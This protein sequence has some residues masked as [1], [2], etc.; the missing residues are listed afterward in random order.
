MR[1]SEG[2]FLMATRMRTKYADG[3]FKPATVA[4]A[5]DEAAMQGHRRHRVVQDHPFDLSGTDAANALEDWLDKEQFHYVWRPTFIEQDACRPA[6]VTEY[7]ELE[8]TW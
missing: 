8:I 7:P 3:L 2:N 6:I 5:I 1:R 4:A